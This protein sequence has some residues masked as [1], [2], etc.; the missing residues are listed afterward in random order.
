MKPTYIKTLTMN[1]PTKML[2]HDTCRSHITTISASHNFQSMKFRI[3]VETRLIILES[4]HNI[5]PGW[6]FYLLFLMQPLDHSVRQILDFHLFPAQIAEQKVTMI[7]QFWPK[8]FGTVFLNLSDAPKIWSVPAASKNS[9]VRKHFRSPEMQCVYECTHE[10]VCACIYVQNFALF[11]FALICL[12]PF[13][14]LCMWHPGTAYLKN[15]CLN[16]YF[17]RQAHTKHL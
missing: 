3:P 4:Q 10:C 1:A 13:F 2:F 11:I 7:S 16:F 12:R 17:T 14:L 5:A 8:T 9:S 6:I 15:C